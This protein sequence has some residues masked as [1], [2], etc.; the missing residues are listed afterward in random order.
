MPLVLLCI[1]LP[2]WLGIEKYQEIQMWVQRE[3]EVETMDVISAMY[4]QEYM[5]ELS[6]INEN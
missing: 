4:R 6:E 1:F 2:I 3:M 5:K